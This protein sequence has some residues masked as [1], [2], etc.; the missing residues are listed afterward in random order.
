MHFLSLP[1]KPR[2]SGW[3][4]GTGSSLLVSL[5]RVQSGLSH[6]SY[7]P[8]CCPLLQ[9]FLLSWYLKG[10]CLCPQ[11]EAVIVQMIGG[12]LKPYAH[13]SCL[14]V[15]LPP[16]PLEIDISQGVPRQNSIFFEGGR[17]VLLTETSLKLLLIPINS[18]KGC[19]TK[20]AYSTFGDYE[21]GGRSSKD[22]FPLWP[23]RVGDSQDKKVGQQTLGNAKAAVNQ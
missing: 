5:S 3:E 20:S 9:S 18:S 15:F 22:C 17:A 11:T 8:N 7:Q 13:N 16:K 2:S 21:V 1:R 14:R 6:W 19:V 4:P 12:R 10:M 23:I